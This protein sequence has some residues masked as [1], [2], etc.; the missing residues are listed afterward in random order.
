MQQNI[1]NRA[2]IKVIRPTLY[3]G[4]PGFVCLYSS[5]QHR[6]TTTQSQLCSAGESFQLE[7][8]TKKIIS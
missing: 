1:I 2:N 8:E 5:Q 4:L 3:E 6:P 7:S